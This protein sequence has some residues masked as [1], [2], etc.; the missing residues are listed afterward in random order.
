MRH[1]TDLDKIQYLCDVALKCL[2][3][4]IKIK[5]EHIVAALLDPRVKCSKPVKDALTFAGFTEAE[6]LIQQYLNIFKIE[7]DATPEQKESQA[8]KL[9]NLLLCDE[10]TEMLSSNVRHEIQNYLANER[11]C[12]QPL[13]YWRENSKK[14]PTIAKLAREI[15]G[16][17]STKKIIEFVL[18]FVIIF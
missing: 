1:N 3:N 17:F 9:V 11:S 18:K 16:K 2:E 12:D 8:D 7:T 13:I 14:F 6:E 10:D 15:L 5:N 4:R